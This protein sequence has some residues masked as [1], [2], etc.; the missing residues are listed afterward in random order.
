MRRRRP[1]APLTGDVRRELRR[2]VAREAAWLLYTGQ[3]HEY[4]MAKEMAAEAL[5]ARVLPSNLEVA[6]ELDRLADELEGPE[7]AERLILMRKEALEVM[8][9]LRPF[10]PKLIGSVWRGMAHR[11]SDIDIEV[12]CDEP[13][14]VEKALRKAG[15]RVIRSEVV[16]KQEGDR[17]IAYYHIYLA[18]PS[19]HE[20]E[21][22]VRPAEER[23]KERKCEIFGDALRGLNIEELEEVLR[24]EPLRKFLPMR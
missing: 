18:M 19:G 10:W 2:K 16:E 13:G 4:K 3:A 12:F 21:V 23:Y 8:K 20:V 11:G 14:E 17:L 24:E 9:A 6:L 22:V 5:G 7:R 15:Y 1:M